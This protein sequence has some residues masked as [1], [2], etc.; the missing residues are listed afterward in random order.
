MYRS[1]WFQKDLD[2]IASGTV[3]NNAKISLG[4]V[5]FVVLEKSSN[6]T[7]INQRQCRNRESVLCFSRVGER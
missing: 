6:R 2:R 1:A 4:H 5:Y 3:T 7:Q